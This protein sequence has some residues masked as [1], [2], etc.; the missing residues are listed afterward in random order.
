M[1]L[2]LY[3]KAIILSTS[4]LWIYIKKAETK[5]KTITF[6]VL[7]YFSY[8]LTMPGLCFNSS[9]LLNIKHALEILP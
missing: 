1:K 5:G 4:I 3:Q 9:M 7:K 8:K 2:N 6:S